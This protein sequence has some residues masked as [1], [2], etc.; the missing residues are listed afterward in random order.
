M[1]VSDEV[2]LATSFGSRHHANVHGFGT[3]GLV[4]CLASGLTGVPLTDRRLTA[5]GGPDFG[6]ES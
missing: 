3:V 2:P 6:A 4:L 1:K 5:D